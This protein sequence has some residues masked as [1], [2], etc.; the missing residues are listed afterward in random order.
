MSDRGLLGL[1]RCPGP[2]IVRIAAL[3]SLGVGRSVAS[4]ARLTLDSDVLW[5]VFGRV[6]EDGKPA[7]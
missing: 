3:A 6:E 2:V 1:R 5:P 4:L 7:L